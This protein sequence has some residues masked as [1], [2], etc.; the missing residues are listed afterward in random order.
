MNTQD[1]SPV[2]KVQGAST[3]SRRILNDIETHDVLLN[4]LSDKPI[5]FS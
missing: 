4:N 3:E 5:R 2:P 1:G